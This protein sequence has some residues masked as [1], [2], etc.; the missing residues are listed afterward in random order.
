MRIFTLLDNYCLLDRASS[1]AAISARRHFCRGRGII[2]LDGVRKS[3]FSLRI[4]FAP[5]PDARARNSFP[6]HLLPAHRRKLSATPC[7]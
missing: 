6:H 7:V 3:W 2:M 4:V 5:M 1:M